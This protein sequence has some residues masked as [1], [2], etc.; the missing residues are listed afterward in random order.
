MTAHVSYSPEILPICGRCGQV[1]ANEDLANRHCSTCRDEHDA[2]ESD[3][4]KPLTFEYF[5]KVLC[6]EFCEVA[7]ED[8]AKLLHHKKTHANAEQ[9]Y[10]CQYCPVKYDQY[11]RLKTH[12][13]S[14]LE[15][16]QSFPVRRL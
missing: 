2:L 10:E 9:K 15:S 1:F 12:S 13:I 11:S 3:T 6:C 5:E 14:H 4:L 7:F 8:V 16:K